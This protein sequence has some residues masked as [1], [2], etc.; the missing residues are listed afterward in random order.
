MVLY[1]ILRAAKVQSRRDYTLLTGRRFFYSEHSAMG[2][3]GIVPQRPYYR[4]C[5]M[6]IAILLVY[7]SS[8]LLC[9]VT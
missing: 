4:S 7:L 1:D 6:R 3:I 2:A 5:R 9:R 8:V